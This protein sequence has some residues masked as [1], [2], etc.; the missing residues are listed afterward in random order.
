MNAIAQTCWMTDALLFTIDALRLDGLWPDILAPSV[1]A[2][3]A[4]ASPGDPRRLKIAW[5]SC[6]EPAPSLDHLQEIKS[7]RLR[8]QSMRQSA[9]TAGSPTL[10]RQSSATGTF[11]NVE[12][13]F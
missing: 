6:Y 11:K 2:A 4:G 9:A 8:R 7:N 1:V 10:A 13:N 3:R 5:S 12:G